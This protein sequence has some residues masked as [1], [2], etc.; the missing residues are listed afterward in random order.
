MVWLLLLLCLCSS[1]QWNRLPRETVQS[2]SNL[3]DFQDWVKP[4]AIWSDL[5]AEPTLSMRLNWTPPQVPSMLLWFWVRFLWGKFKYTQCTIASH[6][7]MSET[8]PWSTV[9][10]QLWHSVPLLRICELLIFYANKKL[11]HNFRIK[12]MI[13]AAFLKETWGTQN[14][15]LFRKICFF[16]LQKYNNN[17]HC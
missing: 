9:V 5:T 6:R 7:D 15:I 11:L 8:Y 16:F 10:C 17:N 4:L 14:M 3:R 12:P 1:N 13:L 2:L